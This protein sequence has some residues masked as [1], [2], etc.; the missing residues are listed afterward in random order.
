MCNGPEFQLKM[1][2]ESGGL[3][4]LHHRGTLGYMA[5]PVQI[6]I[7]SML[8]ELLDSGFALS[9]PRDLSEI[10]YP[11]IHRL[12]GQDKVQS[13]SDQAWRLVAVARTVE[14]RMS[15]WFAGSMCLKSHRR[16]NVLFR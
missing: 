2:L 7:A 12:D 14:P 15:S 11:G 6:A 9:S 10:V 4:I 1:A 5:D 3:R 13:R 8:T 16:R